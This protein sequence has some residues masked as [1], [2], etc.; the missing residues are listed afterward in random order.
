[1]LS[2]FLNHVGES[3]AGKLMLGVAA[4]ALQMCLEL[5]VISLC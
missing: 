5:A 3:L 2:H 4:V 1:M